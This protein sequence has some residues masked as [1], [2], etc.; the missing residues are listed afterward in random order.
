MHG[1]QTDGRRGMSGSYIRHG[2]RMDTKGG[3]TQQ[4]DTGATDRENIDGNEKRSV[5]K[6]NRGDDD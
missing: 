2:K 5:R 3:R 4:A 1:K 6:R